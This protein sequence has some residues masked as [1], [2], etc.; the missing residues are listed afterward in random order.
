MFD[1][2][3]LEILDRQQCLALLAT[4]PIG[5]IVF[6]HRALPAVQPVNFVL[7]GE[8]IVIRTSPGSK[9]TGA[10]HD[11]VVAFEADEFDLDERSGWSVTAVGHA[12]LVLDEPERRRL[13]ALPLRPWA[14]GKR[15]HILRIPVDVVTGRRLI[16]G[17]P[18]THGEWPSNQ[19]PSANSTRRPA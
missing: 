11:A 18:R 10:I 17:T 3:G 19:G 7:D 9:L 16:A 13:E 4:A 12:T 2:A 6:T 8:A 5:R 1:S 15:H 14:P